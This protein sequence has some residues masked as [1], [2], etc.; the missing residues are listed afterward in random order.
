[1]GLFHTAAIL[2]RETEK[3][4]FFHP[5]PRSEKFGNEARHVRQSNYSLSRQDGCCVNL[6]H[7]LSMG[8][9]RFW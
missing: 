9:V 7:R 1:M 2:S 8:V 5:R 3:A 6:A 4:L